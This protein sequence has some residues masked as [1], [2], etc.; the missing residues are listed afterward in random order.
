MIN[1]ITWFSK[2]RLSNHKFDYNKPLNKI[3]NF[4]YCERCEQILNIIKK[5]DVVSNVFIID[6]LNEH[7]QSMS[8]RTIIKHIGDLVKEGKIHVSKQGRRIVYREKIDVE[9]IKSK[10]QIEEKIKEWK[11]ALTR[12]DHKLTTYDISTQRDILSFLNKY[13]EHFQ[14]I[15][16]IRFKKYDDRDE[17]ENQEVIISEIFN[18][19]RQKTNIVKLFENMH[20]KRKQISDILFLIGE[21]PKKK[22]FLSNEQIPKLLNSHLIKLEKNKK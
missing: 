18:T 16:A 5:Y 14:H 2:K 4:Q 17:M 21:T 11:N 8:P 19:I 7:Q 13:F 12:I 10:K 9:L 6:I 22:Y 15:V 20:S 1:L 3:N